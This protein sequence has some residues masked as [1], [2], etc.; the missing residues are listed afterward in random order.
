MVLL[1]QQCMAQHSEIYE[2]RKYWSSTLHDIGH[3]ENQYQISP[4]KNY[5]N[6]LNEDDLSFFLMSILK[7]FPKEHDQNVKWELWFLM[8]F[9]TIFQVY[10]DGQFY[11]WRK[12]EYP[13]KNTNL[14]H[15]TD[16]F[17]HIM[18]Y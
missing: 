1:C 18:L 17:Y 5:A 15:V 14:L 16:K 9:S 11:W 8:P 10:R 6:Y 12:L 13:E 4:Q 7:I 3:H 2:K